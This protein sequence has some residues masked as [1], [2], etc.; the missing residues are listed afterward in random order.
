MKMR[1]LVAD[2]RMANFF[3]TDGMRAPLNWISKL[4]NEGGR[5]Q[6]RDLE[7][8]RPGRAFDSVG[9]GRHAV[10]G[11]RSTKRQQQ[12]RFAKRMAQEIETARQDQAFD[13]LVVMAGP[14]MLGLIREALPELSRTFI[15]AEVPKDLAHLDA[16][17]IRKLIPPDA[18]MS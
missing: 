15:A 10:D 4:E 17:A 12:V 9:A 2:Q 7:T 6:D 13:R 5:L 18:F 11:E 16:R 14:R 1:I 3:E 8:D